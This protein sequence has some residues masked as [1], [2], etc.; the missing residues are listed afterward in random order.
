M[1]LEQ[2]LAPRCR[3]RAPH[4]V[5]PKR[6][7]RQPRAPFGT[8]KARIPEQRDAVGLHSLQARRWSRV[9]IHAYLRHEEWFSQRAGPQEAGWDCSELDFCNED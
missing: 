2:R 3:N 7:G 5:A 1:V 8:Q 4:T 9:R 6:M